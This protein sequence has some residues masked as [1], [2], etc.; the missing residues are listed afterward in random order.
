MM[1]GKPKYEALNDFLLNDILSGKFAPGEKLPSERKLAQQYNI[2]H[3]TV[4]KALN[5]LVSSGYLERVPSVGTFVRK[6]QNYKTVV[7]ILYYESDVHAIFPLVMQRILADIG[8]VLTIF[9]LN[10]MINNP[11]FILDYLEKDPPQ[12]LIVEGDDIC[13]VAWLKKLSAKT[14]TVIFNRCEHP[15]DFDVSYLLSDAVQSGRLAAQLLLRNQHRH[16]GVIVEQRGNPLHA[17]MQ[18]LQGL[19]AELSQNGLK[20]SRIWYSQELADKTPAEYQALFTDCDGITAAFDYYLIPI[21]RAAQENNI[22]IPGKLMLVGRGNTPWAE[23]FDLSSLDLC[24]QQITQNLEQ[25]LE[26]P[27]TN[28]DIAVP[29]QAVYR[30][31]CPK[32]PIIADVT[33]NKK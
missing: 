32:P 9:D 7:A 3:M 1:T 2:A 20:L 22:S 21:I 6:K 31:S 5:G 23:A 12:L 28:F 33:E 24:P 10:V 17:D 15:K 29:P 19:Q 30:K 26:H 14:R 8:Y 16:I 25:I 18:Y 11:D 27:E 13:P 4:N